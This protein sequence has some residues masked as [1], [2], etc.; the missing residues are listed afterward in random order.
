MRAA[1]ASTLLLL[2]FAAPLA[3]AQPERAACP[4]GSWH[5]FRRAE[6]GLDNAFVN[7]IA[8][9]ERGDLYLATNAWNPV[10]THGGGV[11]VLHPDGSWSLHRHTAGGLNGNTVYAVR[12]GHGVVMA[13]T[14]WGASMFWR[15]A[16]GEGRWSPLPA[17]PLPDLPLDNVVSIRADPDGGWWFACASGLYRMRGDVWHR[18]ELPKGRSLTAGSADALAWAPDGR[19]WVGTRGAGIAILDPETGEWTSHRAGPG[20]LPVDHVDDIAFDH[21]GRAWVGTGVGVAVLDGEEWTTH[22]TRD[23]PLADDDVRAVEVDARGRI[24]LGTNLGLTIVDGDR[25]HLCPPTSQEYRAE[26]SPEGHPVVGLPRTRVS[27]ILTLDDG[28]VWLGTF[29]GGLVRFR[30]GER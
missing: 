10:E 21:Q 2:A 24:W 14:L 15:G 9:D 25:W 27:S 6:G 23:S 1:T 20:G 8:M 7:D 3:S 30:E 12:G 16:D 13:G 28:T 4:E 19:L 18:W 29:G 22:S 11:S 5:H 17:S 26:A